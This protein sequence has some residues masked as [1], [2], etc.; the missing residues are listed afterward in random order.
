[1]C[2]VIRKI[3]LL[4]FALT[5]FACTFQDGG[6]ATEEPTVIPVEK[7]V[8]WVDFDSTQ[9]IVMES[10]PMQVEIVIYGDMPTPCHDLKWEISDPDENKAIHIAVYSEIVVGK[11]CAKILEPFTE[12][13]RL[14]DFEDTG[15]SVWIN[16]YKVGEF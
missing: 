9:I 10:Y 3:P 1:M 15:Y 6:D 5:L 13:I 16:D 4:V 14:G 12:R 7:G 2:Q 11:T 8:A